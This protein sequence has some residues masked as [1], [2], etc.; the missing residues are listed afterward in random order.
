[1]RVEHDLTIRRV[2]TRCLHLTNIKY[3]LKRSIE[4]PNREPLNFK[5]GQIRLTC[6][7]VLSRVKCLFLFFFFTAFGDRIITFKEPGPNKVLKDYVIGRERVPKHPP[8]AT[9]THSDKEYIINGYIEYNDVLAYLLAYHILC[10]HGIFI[11]RIISIIVIIYCY[12]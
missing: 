9:Y 11:F 7:L 5:L 8:P 3:N 10:H 1:M 6:I 12:D 2:L 4:R